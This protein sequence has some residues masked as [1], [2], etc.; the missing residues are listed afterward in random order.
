MKKIGLIYRANN[1]EEWADT[2]AQ[3]WMEGMRCALQ[4]RGV[5][6]AALA[7]GLTPFP[8]YERVASKM[9]ELNA[10]LQ[11]SIHLFLVDERMVPLE[12]PESNGGRIQAVFRNTKANVYPLRVDL[13]AEQAA[14]AYEASIRHCLPAT[15]QG[16]LFDDLWLGMGDDGHV[17]SLFPENNI[18]F[19][20]ERLVVAA[21]T[22]AGS[23]RV[24]FTLE[25]L[26]LARRRNLLLNNPK[27]IGLLGSFLEKND[28]NYPVEHLMVDNGVPL[29]WFLL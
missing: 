26:Q 13:D 11:R 16:Q 3:L 10:D 19:A 9:T 7:G 27:K 24:S 21:G 25:T 8:I 5:Y 17:A 4:E 23:T 1:A 12:S 18:R 29:N 14:R 15:H 2:V 20:K 22:H 28:I 6:T